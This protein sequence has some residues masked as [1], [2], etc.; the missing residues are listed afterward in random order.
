ML[1]GV[2]I[3]RTPL[4]HTRN[5]HIQMMHAM[6]KMYMMKCSIFYKTKKE[7]FNIVKKKKE[8]AN[9]LDTDNIR[10]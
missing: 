10:F 1:G 5:K 4:T 7:K 8:E 3:S 2:L 6:D 9:D